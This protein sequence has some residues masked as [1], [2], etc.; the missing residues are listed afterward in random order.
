MKMWHHCTESE[1][2]GTA[3]SDWLSKRHFL[4][5]YSIQQCLS[6]GSKL[7]LNNVNHIVYTLIPQ[8]NMMS[9]VMKIDNVQHSSVILHFKEIIRSK[10]YWWEFLQ[11]YATTVTTN[12]NKQTNSKQL[13]HLNG[14]AIWVVLFVKRCECVSCMAAHCV[15][16]AI[17]QIGN[18]GFEVNLH[19]TLWNKPKKI[20]D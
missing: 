5:L 11:I 3:L 10:P 7:K 9:W 15:H 14:S 4:S 2:Q 17:V 12:T 20:F 8:W 19:K 6:V 16:F 1:E 18:F 13:L